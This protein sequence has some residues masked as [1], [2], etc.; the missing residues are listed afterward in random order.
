MRIAPMLNVPILHG[1]DLL[2]LDWETGNIAM[3][4]T[5]FYMTYHDKVT[6]FTVKF[7]DRL[8]ND[9]TTESG[10]D[11]LIAAKGWIKDRHY[12]VDHDCKKTSNAR[13]Q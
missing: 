2:P 1:K 7:T 13:A 10:F 8:T 3:S 9:T 11:S 6:G 12:G 5:H 4:S